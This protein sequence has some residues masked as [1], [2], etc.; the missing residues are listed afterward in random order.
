MAAEFIS[1]QL[2][3]LTDQCIFWSC[4]FTKVSV[5]IRLAQLCKTSNWYF[6]QFQ[7]PEIFDKVLDSTTVQYKKPDHGHQKDL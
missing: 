2:K 3:K 5:H 7:N 4:C 1:N 6:C